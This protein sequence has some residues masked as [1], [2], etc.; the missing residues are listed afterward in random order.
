MIP[1]NASLVKYDNPV[2]VSRNTD[3]KTPRARALKVSPQQ[4]TGAGPVP[5][6]PAKQKVAATDAK[7]AQQT[8]EILNSILPPR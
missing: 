5:S 3:K 1:P 7:V 4:P 8:D 2:L 6:P